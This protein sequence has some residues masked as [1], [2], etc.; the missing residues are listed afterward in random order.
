MP[1]DAAI[2]QVFTPYCPVVIDFDLKNQVVA[3]WNLCF[4]ASM[5]KAQNE[6]FTQLI[7]WTSCIEKLATI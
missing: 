7:E 5:Q 4:E 3:L 2:G 1:P 6:P